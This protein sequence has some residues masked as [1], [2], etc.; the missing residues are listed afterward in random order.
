[1][2]KKIR[3]VGVIVERLVV[4]IHFMLVVAFHA[5][6]WQSFLWLAF[7]RQWALLTHMY[8]LCTLYSYAYNM[9]IQFASDRIRRTEMLTT[10][11]RWK[12]KSA[13]ATATISVE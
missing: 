5:F 12:E 3:F 6:G 2:K 11:E 1:M 13:T 9:N 4:R 8:A 10:R 7:V